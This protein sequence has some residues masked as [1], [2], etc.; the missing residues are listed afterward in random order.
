MRESSR[1]II[2]EPCGNDKV[3][4]KSNL[5]LD[6]PGQHSLGKSE[7]FDRYAQKVQNGD[8]ID[9]NISQVVRNQPEYSAGQTIAD[10]VK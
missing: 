9:S 7:G 2:G 1:V 3:I 10:L 8:R 4:G 6:S 5:I